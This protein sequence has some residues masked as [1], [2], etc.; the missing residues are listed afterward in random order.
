MGGGESKEWELSAFDPF[1][2]TTGQR[3]EQLEKLNRKLDEAQVSWIAFGLIPPTSFEIRDTY[4]ELVQDCL[5]GLEETSG[6][7]EDLSKTV[8]HARDNYQNG[9]DASAEGLEKFMQA[10][11]E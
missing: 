11:G 4:K 10:L 7:M 5:D 1:V 3:S 2:R 8:K 6:F 9:E